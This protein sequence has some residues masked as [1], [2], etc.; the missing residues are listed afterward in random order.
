MVRGYD[1][2]YGSNYCE[3]YNVYDYTYEYGV[4]Y[5]RFVPRNIDRQ[6][7]TA[8]ERNACEDIINEVAAAAEM[9]CATY[10]Y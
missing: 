6:Y 3:T 7:I 5:T 10:N 1:T 4:G 2:D 9:T 8:D